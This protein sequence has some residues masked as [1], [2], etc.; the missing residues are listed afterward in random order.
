MGRP[1]PSYMSALRECITVA[2]RNYQLRPAWV[3][4][5]SATQRRKQQLYDRLT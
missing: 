3:M 5:A 2:G 4:R 1:K